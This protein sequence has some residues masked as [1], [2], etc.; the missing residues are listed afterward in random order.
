MTTPMLCV[1]LAFVLIWVAR[2]PVIV[3]IW[4]SDMDFDNEL[5]PRQMA[6]LL[7]QMLLQ[8][9]EL[10]LQRLETLQTKLLNAD[11]KKPNLVPRHAVYQHGFA[12][13]F[14]GSYL[15]TLRYLEAL[16]AMPWRFYWDAV[17]FQ[18]KDYPGSRVRLQLHTLSLSEDWIG[19]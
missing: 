10:Q 12:V 5:P 1:C 16:Q 18:V 7:E 6:Q 8:Q 9:G 3:A 11:P 14:S 17:E 4:R 2:I 19:V 13:E 15:A